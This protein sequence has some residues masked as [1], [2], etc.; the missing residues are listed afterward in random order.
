MEE[1][2]REMQQT[3]IY[4]LLRQIYILF[5][6][7]ILSIYIRVNLGKVLYKFILK[8]KIKNKK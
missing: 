4:I 3:E 2:A 5:Q 6:P 8:K 7:L 1:R